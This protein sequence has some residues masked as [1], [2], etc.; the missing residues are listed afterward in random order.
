MA[1]LNQETLKYLVSTQGTKG[2]II[3]SLYR[4]EHFPLEACL[5]PPL[6]GDSGSRWMGRKQSHSHTLHT[7]YTAGSKPVPSPYPSPRPALHSLSIWERGGWKT[8]RWSPPR[9]SS[10]IPQFCL[11]LPTGPRRG[12]K[13]P[14][15]TV[16]GRI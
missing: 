1:S 4:E 14:A 7:L 15:R 10:W 13:R 16:K 11:C 3:P 5:G 12:Q 8:A 2:V 6:W 9:D